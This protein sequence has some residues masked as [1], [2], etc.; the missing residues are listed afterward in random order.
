MS[1]AMKEAWRKHF[2]TL[3]WRPA[4]SPHEHFDAGFRAGL[5][6][7]KEAV[8]ALH[9]LVDDRR[10]YY[11]SADVMAAITALLDEEKSKS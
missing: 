3:D 6:A 4:V 2:K 5:E 11:A 8:V 10:W 9:P 1:N 7:A